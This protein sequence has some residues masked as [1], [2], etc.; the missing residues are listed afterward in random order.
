MGRPKN[1]KEFDLIKPKI[2]WADL[3]V[4]RPPEPPLDQSFTKAA[5]LRMPGS[6]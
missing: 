2:N 1:E 3:Y 6:F 4:P 5:S